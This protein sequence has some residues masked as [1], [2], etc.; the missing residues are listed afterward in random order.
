MKSLLILLLRRV[1]PII[2]FALALGS[3]LTARAQFLDQGALTGVVQDASGAAV[4][5][6]EVTLMNPDTSFTQTTKANESG[7]YV[8]SPIKIGTYTVTVKAQGFEQITQKDIAVNIG[9]R[10]NLNITLKPGAVSETVTVTSAP[11]LLQSQ[12]SSTGQTFTT[13][14]IN[15]TP[16]NSRN[17]I[18]L[19][20]LSAGTTPA[21]GSRAKGT[22]D[23]SANGMRPEENNFVLDGV[24]NN[25]VTPDFLGGAS[26]V[27]NPPPDALQQFQ[28]STSNYSAE[29]GHSAGA[30]VQASVK[31]GTNKVHGDLW[32]YLRNDYLDTHD[33]QPSSFGQKTPEYR[34]NLF[35]GTVGFPIIKDKLFF[36]GDAQDNRI[37]IQVPQSPLTVPTQL[38][39]TGDFS[40]LLVPANLNAAKGI[41]LYEPQN[42]ITPLTCAA[43]A[44][45]ANPTGN[46]VLCMNQISSAAQKVLDAYPLPNSTQF[47]LDN[48]NY[49]Y[50]LKQ[51]LYVWQWDARADYNP[52]S[53]DQAFFRF[54]FLNSRGANEA[55]LGPLLDGGGGN[56]SSN[57]SGTQINY[58]N[59]F[60]VSET[61]TFSPTIVNEI[62]YAFNYSHFGIL[63]PGFN[64]PNAASSLGLGG[65]PEGP[66]APLN[67]GLPTTT[68]SGGGGI[69]SFGSHAYRP[70]LEYADEYQLLDNV[71]W[72]LGNHSLRLGFSY[73]AIRSFVLE[74]P[75]SH[76]AYT[77]NGSITSKPGTAN[78]GSGVADFLT[79]NMSG[80]SISPYGTFNDAGV[81]PAGYVQDDWRA[82]RKLTLNLGVRYE[83][84]QPYKEMIG[85]QGN[86]Y[87]NST[88]VG[89]GSGVYLLPAQD[90]NAYPLNPLFVS[91]L[92]KDNIALQYTNN[93]RLTNVSSANFAPRVGFAFTPDST[94]VVRGGYGLFYQGQQQAG[95]AE[96]LA[97]NYPFLFS[98]SFPVPSGTNCTVGNP[99]ANNGYTLEQGFSSLIA[100]G[101]TSAFST[102]GLVGTSLNIKTTYAMDY[103]L[104]VEQAF[105]NNVV[106]T[107]S[108]VGTVARHLPTGLNSNATMRLLVSGSNQQYLP[109]PDFGGS[110]NLLYVG[111]SSYN[112]LQAKL[113]KRLSH[114]L[115]FSANYT[116][117]H[118]LTDSSNPL[119]GIGY[120]DANII[121][122][123]E[124]MTNDVSDTR[125]RFTFN[126]FYSLPFGRGQAFLSHSN[127]VADALLGGWSTNVTFQAQTGN[128]FSVSTSNQTN[129]VGGTTYAFAVS[130]P[131]GAGGS[132]NPTNPSITC[133]TATHTHA[134]WYNPCA[135][136]NPL[137]ASQLNNY[138]AATNTASP[139]SNAP[140][141]DA[142]AKLFLGGRADQIYGPGFRKLDMSLFKHF[143]TFESQYFELRADVFNL[144]NTPILGQPSTA[145]NNTAGGQIT[146][147]RQLQLDTPNGRFFQLSAKYVF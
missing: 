90:Q 9:Q 94:T 116:W 43:R 122:I 44:T 108:Y 88:G 78:T 140:T 17:A 80:G 69:A 135:F 62:R 125:H 35:G 38:E 82:T 21:N 45:A 16:L 77:Y 85:K 47:G 1:T 89:T 24:D 142:V 79:D 101:L 138:Q 66:S 10:A 105:S 59:N 114:G 65:V 84:F 46:N 63:N 54:S 131:F 93:V 113:Q 70:E 97:T 95:A 48:Q 26:Y 64:N 57:V 106:F 144:M 12:D 74:P 126:G 4:A 145:S 104:A 143:H 129:V 67:G 72:T 76:P 86:F 13:R 15:D 14:E 102:P 51:P 41:Q 98:D 50:S 111:E 134:H 61:H 68:I 71:S 7:V 120:R 49:N 37:I 73:Q 139:S 22:G 29:F 28:V 99:C 100:Q 5:G 109:F 36:F 83:Y 56:G 103:N 118:A 110:S 121:P 27:I 33:W 53:K 3:F 30:L 146:T 147:A 87:A 25:A 75:S 141:T 19:A 11:P 32:E 127:A 6:A 81:L 96:N 132:P 39:R 117:S 92:A 130:D 136:S 52:T 34:Q 31:S 60:L 124:D 42:N 133:A 55:P 119:D 123:R 23:F 58:G 107:L 112:A 20:Q 115:D 91:T 137:P 18:Y 2:V 128:P 8:F 40:E